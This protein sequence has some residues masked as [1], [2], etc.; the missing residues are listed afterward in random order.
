MQ[1]KAIL[2]LADVR[3]NIIFGFIPEGFMIFD[4]MQA[5]RIICR[6]MESIPAKDKPIGNIWRKALVKNMIR[7]KSTQKLFKNG[8]F[9]L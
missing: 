4:I 2:C 7:R 3:A 5:I 8:V 1:G 6:L 9:L